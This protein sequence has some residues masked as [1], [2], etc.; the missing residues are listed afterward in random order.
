MK[1]EDRHKSSVSG[2]IISQALQV[3]SIP[4]QEVSKAKFGKRNKD[5]E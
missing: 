3:R 5:G 1:A 4:H 2:L